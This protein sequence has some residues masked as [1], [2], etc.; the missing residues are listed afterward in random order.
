MAGFFYF[1]KSVI[2]LTMAKLI[3]DIETIGEDF[4]SLDETTREVLTHWIK[5]ESENDKEYQ[6]AL[7]ELKEGLGFSPLTGEIVVIGILDYEKDKGAVYYQAPG[8]KF[9]DFEEDGIVFKQMDE[10]E[11]LENFWKGAE[12]YTEFISFN[13]RAF[14]APFLMIRSAIHKIRP[15]KDLTRARYLYQQNPSAIHIDLFDQLTFYGSLR[16]KGG[17]HLWSRAFGIKSPKAS[18][19]SGDDVARLFKE[20]KF[21]EIA[22]YN[23]GDLRATKELYDYWQNYI[24]F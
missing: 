15:T 11:M 19:V 12:K 14:D 2:I 5:K 3:F 9:K 13:G 8:E 23:T 20:K 10:K 21:Q 4:E 6:I 24:R 7:G 16:R 22:K 17:L 18:G 1:D